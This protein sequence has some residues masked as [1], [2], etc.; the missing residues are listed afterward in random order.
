MSYYFYKF[1]ISNRNFK[2]KSVIEIGSGLAQFAMF[3][4]INSENLIYVCVDIEEMIP[5]AYLSI[6]ENYPNND[7]DLFLPHEVN[8]FNFS[9]SK[10]KVLFLT[11]KQYHQIDKLIN[12]KIDL[13]VNIESFAEMKISVVN[14]YLNK[15]IDFLNT[16]AMF[17]TCN[18]L[19]RLVDRTD[20]IQPD[21][22]KYTLFRDY[23]L[24]NYNII[25]YEVDQLRSYIQGSE[26]QENII[27]LGQLKNN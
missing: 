17:F 19:S 20:R 26:I 3:N 7:V 5:S 22:K 24:N 11:P 23:N 27:Y 4:L 8:E 1:S 6:I 16:D 2:Y 10:K 14:D 25:L 12:F 21:I 15:S 18:R 13:F 9:N